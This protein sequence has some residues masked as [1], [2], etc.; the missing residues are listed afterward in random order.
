MI[1][2]RIRRFAVAAGGRALW[3]LTVVSLSAAPAV[4]GR[5][6][7][8]YE[9]DPVR[10]GLILLRE[11]KAAEAKLRFEEA[12]ANDWEVARA[13][14]GLAEVHVRQ[15][16]YAAAEP[17]FR[18]SL[19]ESAKPLPEARAAL[20]LLLLRLDRVE[21]AQ[22]EIERA[23][24]EDGDLWD[25]QYA[26]AL[27]AVR[28]K[29]FDEAKKLLE[30]GKKKKGL[31]EG[32]D[33]Y[34]HGV[35][36][37]LYEQGDVAGAE[38]AALR[39]RTLNP[40]EPEYVGLVADIYVG[41]GQPGLAIQE[42][43]R[44]LETPGFEAS[45]P[46][47]HEM[48]GLYEAMK[49]PNEALRSYQEAV[50]IDSTFAPALLDV[51]RLYELGKVHDRAWAAYDRYLRLAPDDIDVLVTFT[52]VSLDVRQFKDAQA[53]AKRA[54]AMDSTR[55]DIRLLYAR[56]SAQNK[57][58]ATAARLYASVADTTLF[59]AIDHVRLGQMDFEA[60]RW[61]GARA[62][63]QTALAMDSTSA[64][65]WFILGMLELRVEDAEA[66]VRALGKA[67]EL[68]P[69]FA[70]ASLNLG[71]A[72]LRAGRKQE[73]I[74]ALRRAQTLAPENP[75]VLVSLAEALASADSTAAAIEEYLG[76]IDIDPSNAKAHRGLGLCQIQK[77][78]WPEAVSSLRQATTLD[79]NNADGWAMLGQ[80]YLGLN[81]I[82]RAKQA[83]ER[84]LAIKP[85][86]TIGKS[87]L[88]VARQARG[89]STGP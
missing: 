14:Y 18:Q 7:Y 87:V 81:D 70:A 17:L 8:T 75:Q 31:K 59:E 84:C 42:Y 33:R 65:G 73:G 79:G 57:D 29:Q 20:G 23:L 66:A 10:L 64:E 71:I 13:H 9:T 68:A 49:D 24:R 80:A 52:R 27:L 48:G 22:P 54:F 47:F 26:K 25:A 16:A 30:K 39:A 51:G 11:G 44:L 69:N 34:H 40:T 62:H 53:A 15:G 50:K 4:H 83:A 86:H 78:S 77:K 43:R 21:E 28:E 35:A 63:L 82:P 3:L 45:A 37:L 19:A 55:A 76:V 2:R 12:I 38:Q 56:A 36:L 67:A 6:E 5:S 46:F 32:E 89:A 85:G 88:D 61:D 60:E 72:E 74:A 58:P 1:S 41:T